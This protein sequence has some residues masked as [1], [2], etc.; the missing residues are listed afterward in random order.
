MTRDLKNDLCA[1]TGVSDDS[2]NK[3]V[4]LCEDILCHCVFESITDKEQ[5][6]QVD[7][8]IGELYIRRDGDLIKYKFIPND[9]FDNKVRNTYKN[10]ASPLIIKANKSLKLK[11][12]RAYKEL[13]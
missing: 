10:G 2:A 1:I 12:D 11:F 7:I 8:G 3:V 9:E 13:I 6:T 4:R 5:L